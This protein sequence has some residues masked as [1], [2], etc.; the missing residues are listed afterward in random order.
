MASKK[1]RVAVRRK[2]PEGQSTL[3]YEAAC[4][5]QSAWVQGFIVI[6]ASI[7]L[8]SAFAA[9]IANLYHPDIMA[10]LRLAQ[11]TLIS[12]GL[13]SPKPVEKML[14]SCAV[15]FFPSCAF[16][17]FFALTPRFRKVSAGSMRTWYT[18]TVVIGAVTLLYVI[19]HALA[20]ANPF[21]LNSGMEYDATAKTNWAFYFASTFIYKH[22]PV[23]CC[24]LFPVALAY[25]LFRNKLPERALPGIAK[26]EKIIAYG[27]SIAI[28]TVI[29]LINAFRFPYTWGN[30][31][32]F[33]AVYY[34]VVQVYR[35][36]PLL[37]DHFTNNYGLYPHFVVPVMKLF[38]LS[39]PSFSHIMAF[40]LALCFIF[41]ALFFRHVIKNPLL[42]LFGM[43]AVFFHCYIFS[44]IVAPFDAGFAMTP[45]RWVLPFSLLLYASLYLRRPR[46]ALYFSSLFMYALGILWCPDFGIFTFASLVG[47][48]CFLEL[49][50]RPV[51]VIAQKICLHLFFAGLAIA[52]A[53]LCSPCRS[54]S[55]SGYFPI[56]RSSSRRPISFSASGSPCCPFLPRCIPGCW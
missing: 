28:A 31:Y 45:I 33:N 48:Y 49:E 3:Q 15:L 40:L 44:R 13:A 55:A 50:R 38:G 52:A 21:V 43:T 9:I 32:D 10:A 27:S 51:A 42:I 39:V 54:G 12:P 25:L 19:Y 24:A 7:G 46:K 37:V 23:Y 26:A 11:D 18:V 2:I 29:F 16:V 53:F 47:L 17:L 36:V 5:Y 1:R 56:S 14:F 8:Y 34:S 6:A 4:P 20:S 30:K 41:L 35:G 22:L